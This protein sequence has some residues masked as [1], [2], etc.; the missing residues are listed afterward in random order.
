MRK[1]I[2]LYLLLLPLTLHAMV[3]HYGVLDILKR[4][5]KN[6]VADS[7]YQEAFHEL[8]NLGDEKVIGGISSEQLYPLI[9]GLRVDLKRLNLMADVTEVPDLKKVILEISKQKPENQLAPQ[10]FEFFVKANA[11]LGRDD[12]GRGPAHYAV[13]N[14]NPEILDVLLNLSPEVLSSLSPKIT[15]KQLIDDIDDRFETPLMYAAKG[16]IKKKNI[17]TNAQEV[18]AEKSLGIIEKL[19]IAGAS[20][21]IKNADGKTAFDLATQ[22]VVNQSDVPEWKRVRELLEQDLQT[23]ISFQEFAKFEKAIQDRNWIVARDLYQRIPNLLP[24]AS[25]NAPQHLQTFV[26][27]FIAAIPA[28]IIETADP[29]LANYQAALYLFEKIL[30][31]HQKNQLLFVPLDQQNPE[32]KTLLMLAI[33]NGK[34]DIVDILLQAGSRTDL[35]DKNG[36]TPVILAALFANKKNDKKVRARALDVLEKVAQRSKQFLTRVDIYDKAPFDYALENDDV[37]ILE[38][39]VQNG[40]NI[41]AT[42]LSEANLK[43]K[44]NVALYLTMLLNKNE[45]VK[46]APDLKN[47]LDELAGGLNRL[48]QEL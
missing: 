36:R 28:I 34:F 7:N 14:G 44:K 29:E 26:K 20:K 35:V 47:S 11:P 2:M 21:E 3:P 41:T 45:S 6:I 5:V 4:M 30:T 43:K 13:L 25:L 48:A 38:L 19:I 9:G 23:G 32:G 39:L 37:G 27:N 18:D 1:K 15:K 46:K 42:M 10:L 8:Q 40:L 33:E 12:Y 17:G 24:N 22:V 31:Q 16:V